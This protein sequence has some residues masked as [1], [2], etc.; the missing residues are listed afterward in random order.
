MVFVTIITWASQHQDDTMDD[1]TRVKNICKCEEHH[2][3]WRVPTMRHHQLHPRVAMASVDNTAVYRRI[4]FRSACLSHQSPRRGCLGLTW[5][6]MCRLTHSLSS[7]YITTLMRSHRRAGTIPINKKSNN[8]VTSGKR[9][10]R[11]LLSICGSYER[12]ISWSSYG[13]PCGPLISGACKNFGTSKRKTTSSCPRRFRS[14]DSLKWTRRSPSNQHRASII[15]RTSINAC[16][17]GLPLGHHHIDGMI[18][19]Q[20]D[21]SKPCC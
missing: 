14:H 19:F 8:Y 4:W 9:P 21:R 3:L 12:C 11:G 13:W 16:N 5:C 2:C 10:T 20:V 17:C 15:G 18:S 7:S 6:H 1:Y